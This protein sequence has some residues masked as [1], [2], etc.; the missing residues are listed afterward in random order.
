MQIVNIKIKDLNPYP[1]NAKKHD[2][3]QIENVAESIKQ[4][5]MVQPIVVDKDNVVIIGH[6]RLEACKKLKF[7]EVPCVRTEDLDEEQVAKLRLLDNKLNESDWDFDLLGEELL[8]LDMSD[9]ELDWGLPN[10]DVNELKEDIDNP[11]TAKVDIP[12]YNITGECPN[13]ADLVD[14][15]KAKEL[16]NE[17]N[18]SNITEEQKEFLI[19]A[20]KR[21]LV[22]D[23]A[24]IAEYYAHQDKEMQELMEKSVLVI[25]DFND[26]IKNGYA[27]LKRDIMEFVEDDE[28]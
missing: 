18:N 1:K 13:I 9:F 5:G 26:A 15:E 10:D 19:K 8:E 23:Y 3:T 22:F 28:E 7:K 25:I 21:H 20:T 4:F 24:K 2:K 16:E 17:I 11:Y 12:Q 6:C 27:E 14:I